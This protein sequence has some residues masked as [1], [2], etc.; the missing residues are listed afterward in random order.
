MYMGTIMKKRTSVKREE[1]REERE[2]VER[3]DDSLQKAGKEILREGRTYNKK[4]RCT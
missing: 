4:L 1:R 2:E 3:K